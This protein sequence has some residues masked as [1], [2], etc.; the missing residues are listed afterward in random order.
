MSN[1]QN[2]IAFPSPIAARDLLRDTLRA[3][4]QATLVECKLR[5]RP[6]WDGGGFD[7]AYEGHVVWVRE[8]EWVDGVEYGSHYFTVRG[9]WDGRRATLDS[10]YYGGK[11][12]EEGRCERYERDRGVVMYGTDEDEAA[13][14]AMKH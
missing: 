4:I 11:T 5:V 8:Q 7:V 1:S 9:N 6:T 13:I 2:M 12:P 10:G 3:N 14:R